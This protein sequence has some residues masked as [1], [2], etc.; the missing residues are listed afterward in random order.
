M[1][2]IPSYAL[3]CSQGELLKQIVAVDFVI[4]IHNCSGV[5][6]WVGA[7]GL[8]RSFSGWIMIMDYGMAWVG[9]G[10]WEAYK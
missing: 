7:L 10:G 3:R 6:V 2:S 9:L 1:C 4:R 5:R 8:M